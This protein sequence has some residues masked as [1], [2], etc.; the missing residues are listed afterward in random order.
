[1]VNVKPAERSGRP[2]TAR[3]RRQVLPPAPQRPPPSALLRVPPAAATCPAAP[4]ADVLRA[5]AFRAPTTAGC[6][7]PA[8][9]NVLAHIVLAHNAYPPTPPPPPPYLASSAAASGPRITGTM[10]DCAGI[11]VSSSNCA[12]RRQSWSRIDASSCPRPSPYHVRYTPPC[13]HVRPARPTPSKGNCEARR[14]ARALKFSYIFLHFL[15]R[16]LPAPGAWH[17]T[18]VC[19]CACVCVCV[20]TISPG[21]Y[22]WRW[23]KQ[24][25]PG[26]AAQ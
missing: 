3:P 21:W 24:R 16:F 13:L 15:R 19:V 22:G 8:P 1:M 6:H 14:P 25:P 10:G 4:W 2:A 18:D 5:R 17:S 11:P 23:R 26:P 9:Q 12:T 7:P 20:C